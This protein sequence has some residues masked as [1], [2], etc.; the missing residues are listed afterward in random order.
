MPRRSG[1][2]TRGVFVQ[3]TSRTRRH[4]CPEKLAQ[5]IGAHRTPEQEALRM[6]ATELLEPRVLRGPLDPFGDAAEVE[7]AC[8]ADDRR[9]EPAIPAV[10]VNAVDKPLVES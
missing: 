3:P 6:V 5:R 4:V 8:Q 1:A 7:L 2:Q 10:A 9:S